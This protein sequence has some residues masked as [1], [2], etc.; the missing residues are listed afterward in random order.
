MI[1]DD[2]EVATFQELA[3]SPT[4]AKAA[5]LTQIFFIGVRETTSMY[6]KIFSSK[7]SLQSFMNPKLLGGS[8]F[9]F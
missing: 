9:N 3:R 2:N 7:S 5:R 8:R 6:L 1:Q 4:L